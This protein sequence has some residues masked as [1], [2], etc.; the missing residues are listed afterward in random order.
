[1]DDSHKFPFSLFTAIKQSPGVCKIE[2]SG[3]VYENI[4]NKTIGRSILQIKGSVSANNFIE[5]SNLSL[6]GNYLYIM[7]HVVKN[8]IGTLHFEIETREGL[9]LRITISTLYDSIRFL[10]RSL[11]MP[12]PSSSNWMILCVDIQ[13]VL[14]KYCASGTNSNLSFK[15]IKVSYIL[16]YSIGHTF[17]ILTTCR[18]YK[19]ARIYLSK[20]VLLVILHL[21]TIPR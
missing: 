7:Y 3:G 16:I 14:T 11:R 12:L 2:R 13:S 20:I 19:S 10:G 5:Y 1:M 18:S 9:S 17:N 15:S 21:P 6:N 4:F 8:E